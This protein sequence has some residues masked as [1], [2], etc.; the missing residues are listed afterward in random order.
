MNSITA[1]SKNLPAAFNIFSKELD[2]NGVKIYAVSQVTDKQLNYVGNVLKDLLNKDGTGILANMVK[3]GAAMT[4][5]ANAEQRDSAAGQ[6]VFES[7]PNRMLQDLQ[8]D[9][10][11]PPGTAT[12]RDATVEEVTH[13]IHNSGI[14]A[15]NPAA[16][17]E[18]DA[19]TQ[20]AIKAGLYHPEKITGLPKQD[21]DD[22]YLA[23]G[24]EAYYGV[25]HKDN[26]A[27]GIYKPSNKNEL[28]SMDPELFKIIEKLFPATIPSAQGTA[29][30][31]TPKTDND[32]KDKNKET[33]K[34]SKTDKEEE[35]LAGNKEAGH[36]DN[37]SQYENDNALYD[38]DSEF[39]TFA[40]YSQ[41]YRFWSEF[42]EFN[43]SATN[44]P[45]GYTQDSDN[46]HD[47]K[48]GT[49]TAD[50]DGVDSISHSGINS[51][52]HDFWLG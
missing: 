42:E 32:L 30:K 44:N 7:A 24:V 10:I 51:F 20:K 2:V 15:A 49:S 4:M 3:N 33:D 17:K 48:D 39:E 41:S 38:T 12:T 5:F 6:K 31:D 14:T 28:K 37:D 16:Q 45:W 23:A 22:E 9:E 43:P 40:E 29:N 47:S 13:L 35:D 25:T 18:L 21:Y 11:I 50:W 52:N 27:A 1:L 26:A 46:S 36:H 34:E 19:A 8:A